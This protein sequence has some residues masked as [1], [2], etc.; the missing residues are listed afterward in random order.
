M[1]C[2]VFDNF[3]GIKM[4]LGCG[5]LVS[6]CLISHNKLGV[7]ILSADPILRKCIVTCNQSHGVVS[8]SAE[9]LLNRSKVEANQIEYNGQCGVQCLGERNNSLIRH[10][11]ISFNKNVGICI[12]DGAYVKVIGN[13]VFKN[14]SMGILVHRKASAHLERNIIKKNVKANL[15]VC[16]PSPYHKPTIFNNII[17]KSRC[18]GIILLDTYNFLIRQV[19][20]IFTHSSSS[21]ILTPMVH[22]S[23]QYYFKSPLKN[24]KATL[25]SQYMLPHE[26]I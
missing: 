10:N 6:D 5:A 24:L 9:G 18:E 3:F 4:A 2:R 19:L 8:A 12:R 21:N 20:Q 22:P 13:S 17:K 23:I 26:H 14:M 15:A 1:E 7:L 16:D 25:Y 11:V